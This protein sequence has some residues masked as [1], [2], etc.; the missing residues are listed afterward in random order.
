MKI[1]E[2]IE[3][4]APGILPGDRPQ[5]WADLGC[6][7]GTFTYALAHL[8]PPGSSIIAVDNLPQNLSKTAGHHASIQFQ[9]ADF[10]QDGLALPKLDGILMA[11]SLHY[12]REKEILVKRLEPCFNTEKQFLIVEYESKI[13]NRWVPFPIAFSELSALFDLLNYEVVTKVNERRSSFGG[14]MY[15][16]LIRSKG[17]LT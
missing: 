5:H 6:G 1:Q 4:I 14:T 12:I 9:Q 17:W 3:F 2:A 11:N 7:N 10:S 13:P 16:A 8:L 15:A